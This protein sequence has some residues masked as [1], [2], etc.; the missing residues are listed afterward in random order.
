[1]R[2]NGKKK[3]VIFKI[4]LPKFVAKINITVACLNNCA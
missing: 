2:E 4:V 1:M 3:K